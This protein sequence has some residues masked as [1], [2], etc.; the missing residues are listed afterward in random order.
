[1]QPLLEHALPVGARDIHIPNHNPLDHNPHE[2]A[3]PVELLPMDLGGAP[4]ANHL[5]L[6]PPIDTGYTPI[7]CPEDNA[8]DQMFVDTDEAAGSDSINTLEQSSSFTSPFTVA[9]VKSCSQGLLDNSSLLKRVLSDRHK[10]RLK[11]DRA[12]KR[13]CMEGPSQG[14]TDAG[15]D[16]MH[17]QLATSTSTETTVT[18]AASCAGASS[19]VDG[20][21]PVGVGDGIRQDEA[22]PTNGNDFNEVHNHIPEAEDLA[23]HAPHFGHHLAEHIDAADADN[24]LL[25]NLFQEPVHAG[26]GQGANPH[27]Q[28]SKY[29]ARICY[30]FC[31]YHKKAT[32][33]LCVLNCLV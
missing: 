1:M 4:P 19:G 8:A 7:T 2:L 31:G 15:A 28:L 14:A 21:T 12:L 10:L 24:P 26:R 22:H 30:L 33:A 20:S 3:N 13:L 16:T 29:F 25:I 17:T 5:P 27:A 6:R 18:T 9:S 32:K 11:K 23:A